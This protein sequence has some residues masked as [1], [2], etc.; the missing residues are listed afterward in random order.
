MR[1]PMSS[2]RLVTTN[3]LLDWT[4]FAQVLSG[5][6]YDEILQKERRLEAKNFFLHFPQQTT[7]ESNL[8]HIMK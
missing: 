6:G 3:L 2:L 1:I 8:M 7:I 4:V 5:V